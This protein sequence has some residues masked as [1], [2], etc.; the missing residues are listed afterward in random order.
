MIIITTI[1]TNNKKFIPNFYKR[2]ETV[3][4]DISFILFNNYFGETCS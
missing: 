4:Y 3:D 2:E 1:E